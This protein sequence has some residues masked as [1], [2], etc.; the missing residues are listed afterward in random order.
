[1]LP[2]HPSHCQQWGKLEILSL[3][4]GT[5]AL[6]LFHFVDF[7]YWGFPVVLAVNTVSYS[8]VKYGPVFLC[9]LELSPGWGA[10]GRWGRDMYI[11]A[12]YWGCSRKHPVLSLGTIFFLDK[13]NPSEGYCTSLS[14]L[15]DWKA[16]IFLHL[17]TA[18]HIIS[19][20]MIATQWKCPPNLWK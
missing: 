10:G 12:H 14:S 3:I 16:F 2:A 17:K 19:N 4:E 7:R 9:Y 15:Y 18:E 20:L 11:C 1:M 13:V 6:L 8:T 5:W